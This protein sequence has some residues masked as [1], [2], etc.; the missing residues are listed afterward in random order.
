M[1]NALEI[2]GT[3]YSLQ[4]P[5]SFR[6]WY[7]VTPADFVFAL[8]GGRFITHLRK[9][10]EP[11]EGLANFF[12]SGVLHLRE[13]LGPILWQFPPFLGFNEDRFKEFFDLLPRDTVEAARL[14]KRHASFLKNRC[15]LE[16]DAKRTVRHAVE[17]RHDS[18]LSD[19]FVEL[20]RKHGVA[21]VV[22]DVASKF[23][24]AE[25]VTANWV[26]VRLHGSRQ[27]YAS[28]YTP[29][30][31]ASWAAKVRAWGRGGEPPKAR[32]IGRQAKPA[33]KGRDV[34]VF[35]DN[36]NVKLRAPVDARRMA[37]ELGV[38]PGESSSEVLAKL[39][40]QPATRAT[41]SRRKRAT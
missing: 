9:L 22:A 3:F 32:R 12:A 18:F 11:R 4:R 40:V 24:T 7:E 33:A 10:N 20:L 35:F 15:Y 36:T 25:D 27:L 2:N 38:G 23:P 28:G 16:V 37:K 6:S 26:Y 21:L 19:R 1:F 14:G 30:E 17:F 8:K 34:F 5:G 13:K 41:R 29:R 39:G 31:I